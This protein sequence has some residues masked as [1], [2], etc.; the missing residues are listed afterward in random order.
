MMPKIEIKNYELPSGRVPYT[1]WFDSLDWTIR[2]IVSDRMEEVEKGNLG[3]TWPIQGGSGI[4]EFRFH[5][6]PGYRIYFVKK[7]NSLVILLCA[8]PKKSQDRDIAK[9]KKYFK[10]LKGWYER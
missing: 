4:F 1:D 3:D 10:D 6:S 7:G 2:K 5:I 9:A 8:G